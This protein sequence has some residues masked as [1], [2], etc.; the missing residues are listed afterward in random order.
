MKMHHKYIAAP[1]ISLQLLYRAQKKA[2]RQ[3]ELR[4]KFDLLKV[5]FINSYSLFT[6]LITAAGG[7]S[8]QVCRNQPVR[9]EPGRLNRR[10]ATWER[11]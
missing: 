6:A 9:E 5:N 10:R 7:E 1:C 4:K 2:E 11:V 8:A 3:Q